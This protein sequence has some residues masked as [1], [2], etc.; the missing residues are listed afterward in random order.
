MVW[1]LHL[2]KIKLLPKQTNKNPKKTKTKKPQKGTKLSSK[3]ALKTCHYG[4]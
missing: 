2:N 1:E 4:K 3:V